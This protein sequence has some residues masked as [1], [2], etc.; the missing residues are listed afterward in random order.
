MKKFGK[1][2]CHVVNSN[3][4]IGSLTTLQISLGFI[5]LFEKIYNGK[6][7]LVLLDSDPLVRGTDTDPYD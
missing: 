6:P 2:A 5:E 1:L 7:I 4:A 3:I